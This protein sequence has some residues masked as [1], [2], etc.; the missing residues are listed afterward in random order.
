MKYFWKDFIKQN[1]PKA[2][3]A[4]IDH[5]IAHAGGAYF[6]SPWEKALIVR[7]WMGPEISFLP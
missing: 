3:I 2:R 5:H 6:T 1:F 7:R 4:K